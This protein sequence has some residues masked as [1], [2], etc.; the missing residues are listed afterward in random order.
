[1]IWWALAEFAAAGSGPWVIG[2]GGYTLYLGAE[3]QRFNRLAIQTGTER[4]VIDVGEGVST[5]GLK[6]IGT[7]GIGSRSE[8]ELAIPWY[9]IQANRRDTEICALLGLGACQ[10]TEGLGIVQLRMKGLALDEFFGAP[11]SLAIGGEAR[12]GQ[13]TARD[14]ERITNVGEGTFDLGPYVD[15]GRTAALGR[16]YWS[17]WFEGAFR[18]RVPTTD[19]YP[20]NQGDTAVPGSE[21]TGTGELVLGPTTTFGIGPQISALWRP[22]G[23]DFDELDLGDPDRFA[24]LNIGLVR[25]GAVA[26]VRTRGIAAAVSFAQ[27]VL[28]VNNPSDTFVLSVGIQFDGRLTE[29]ADG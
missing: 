26:V 23:L 25:A 29:A 10:T 21:I 9:R 8:I 6:A 3:A 16:G 18:Y 15:V 28:S 11:F 4:D 5:L 27:T 14:R 7:L 2:D 24:A 1:M 20:A 13:L 19:A 12:F 17:G 22:G